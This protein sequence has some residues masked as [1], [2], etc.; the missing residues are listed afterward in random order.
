MRLAGYARVSIEKNAEDLEGQLAGIRRWAKAN[1]FDVEIVE[2]VQSAAR[3]IDRPVFDEL[4]VRIESGVYD[5]L[6]VQRLDRFGRSLSDIL[7]TIDR[8]Q[9]AGK[10]F[11]AFDSHLHLSPD[12]Q[13]PMTRLFFHILAVFAE[14][15]RELLKARLK[16][17]RDVARAKGVHLGRPPRKLPIEEVQRLR[18]MGASLKFLG[19]SYSM[20][21]EWIGIHLRRFEAKEYPYGPKKIPESD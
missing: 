15:E 7:Y 8:L 17:G 19:K 2:E 4:L 18:K 5:G 14:F 13:D 21:P 3:G 12:E 9:K 20:S 16:M 11:Y 6:V 1:G 10:H